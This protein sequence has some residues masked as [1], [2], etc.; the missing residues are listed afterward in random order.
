[1]QVRPR[2]RLPAGQRGDGVAIPRVEVHVFAPAAGTQHEPAGPAGR[3]GLRRR[4]EFDAQFLAG[5]DDGQGV[6]GRV[7]ERRDLA[8]GGTSRVDAACPRV[9]PGARSRRPACA[10]RRC[11]DGRSPIRAALR[12]PWAARA[13]SPTAAVRRRRRPRDPSRSPARSRAAAPSCQAAATG[14]AGSSGA[15]C[16]RDTRNLAPRRASVRRRRAL[17]ASGRRT[18][19]RPARRRTRSGRR[20]TRPSHRSSAPDVP[21]RDRARCRSRARACAVPSGR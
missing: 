14:A 20:D 8:E 11:C 10:A 15:A 4:C 3:R 19:R 16:R 5:P 21:G 9:A 12:P 7:D 18:R 17:R 2:R 13:R 1:M 6:V